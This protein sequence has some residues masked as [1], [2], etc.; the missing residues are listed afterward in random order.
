MNN[1][2]QL[3]NLIKIAKKLKE[4]GITSFKQQKFEEAISKFQKGYTNLEKDKESTKESKELCLSLL[5]NMSNCY[6]N[7]KKY[8][9][10]KD[11]ATEAL[12]LSELNPKGYYY[13]GIAFAHLEHFDKAEKDYKQLSEL[14]S[15]DDPGIKYLRETIDNLQK[16]KAKRESN[17]FGSKLKKAKLYDDKKIEPKKEEVS[18]KPQD[19]QDKTGAVDNMLMDMVNKIDNGDPVALA[20]LPVEVNPKNPRVFMDIAIGND[21]PKRIE[22]ELFIDKVPKCVLNF[23]NILLGKAKAKQNYKGS[24]FYKLVKGSYIEGGDYENGDGT[25]GA[26]MYGRFFR[27][28]KLRYKLTERGLLTTCEI[29]PNIYNSR[30]RITLNALEELNGKEIVFG[31]IIKGIEI[32]EEL[33]AVEVGQHNKPKETIKIVETGDLKKSQEKVV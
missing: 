29:E 14:V 26:T 16:E 8:E 31:R 2:T 1:P 17:L 23:K 28:E 13:R 6:N 32:L 4:E 9:Q 11:K 10:C 12:N 21:S 19:E 25:G 24:C 18:S 15:S 22:M 7:L 27:G 20:D 33:N 5:L 30:F 3:E